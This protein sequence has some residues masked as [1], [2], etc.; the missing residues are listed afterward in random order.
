MARALIVGC[1]HRGRA[2]G[3]RLLE[4]GWVVRGTTR[5]PAGL[6]AIQEVGIEPFEADPDRIGTLLDPIEG[7]TAIVWLLGSAAGDREAVAALHGPRLERLLSEIVDTPVRGFVYEAT[8]S[9]DEA[10]LSGGAV[11]VRAAAARWRIPVELIEAEPGEPGPWLED[12]AGAV[13]R[14]VA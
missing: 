4:A 14:I 6:A 1:G 2:L 8:G 13:A 5:S 11:I 12:A 3:T 7:V 9:V 10:V